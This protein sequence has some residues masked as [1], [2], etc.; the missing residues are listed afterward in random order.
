MADHIGGGWGKEIAD[1]DHTEAA[2]VIR[3]T[4]I[5]NA[6]SCQVASVPHRFH[7]VS[8]IR[9]R[10]LQVGDIVFEVSGGSKGQPV[11]RTLLVTPQFLSAFGDDAVMCASFCKR[12]RPDTAG[13]GS[14][15]LYLSLLEG[16]ESGEIEQFQVQSTGISNFKWTE[17]IAKTKRVI[18][19]EPLR[20]RFRERVA[21]LFSQIA[22]L[23]LQIH[24]LRSTRDLL[25][26]RLLSGQVNL[27]EN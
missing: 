8:N 22:T 24:N 10:R 3:G 12:V 23:G 18:P 27:A 6:R 17:Y 20:V 19:P 25:L 26:P 13:Y 9:S 1:E 7:T 15:L 2:W 21:P 16:Y 11:G 14:E 5:P 4:D